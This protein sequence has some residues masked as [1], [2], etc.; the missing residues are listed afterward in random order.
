MNERPE[1]MYKAGDEADEVV[2]FYFPSIERME[3]ELEAEG[4]FDE[5]GEVA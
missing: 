1:F 5:P 2:G 3:E 4:F